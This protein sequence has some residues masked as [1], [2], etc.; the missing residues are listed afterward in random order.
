[1]CCWVNISQYL[2]DDIALIFRL[3]HCSWTAWL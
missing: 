1:V 3:K 2:K